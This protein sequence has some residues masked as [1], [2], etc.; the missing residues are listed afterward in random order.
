[1]GVC[2]NEDRTR[3]LRVAFVPIVVFVVAIVFLF[4]LFF[5]IGFF[6]KENAGG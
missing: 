3:S 1:L 2:G 6:T 4:I 5:V